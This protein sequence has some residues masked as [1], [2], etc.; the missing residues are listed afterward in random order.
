[1]EVTNIKR[2]MKQRRKFNIISSITPLN[3]NLQFETV[4]NPKLHFNGVKTLILNPLLCF[5]VFVVVVVFVLF[6]CS[7][8]VVWLSGWALC[9]AIWMGLGRIPVTR[10]NTRNI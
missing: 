6:C 5:I 9:W 3:E 2:T 1:M 4:I 7:V 10:T 8:L